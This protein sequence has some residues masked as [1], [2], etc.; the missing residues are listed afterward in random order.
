MQRQTDIA[1]VCEGT[2]ALLLM[3]D[4]LI[5]ADPSRQL[6]VAGTQAYSA[7]AGA[8]VDCGDPSRAA[9]LSLKA[10]E[11][12]TALLFRVQQFREGYAKP[13]PEFT[14]A[15][16]A[17]TVDDVEPLFWGGYSWAQ[18]VWY[19]NG[20]PVAMADL[21]KI[22]R[23]MQ[24]VLELDETVYYGAA[25][26]FLGVYFG[27]RPALYGGNF[28]L[29]R[30]HFER[31]LAIGKREF[32]MAQVL[33]AENYARMVFDRQL[34]ESLLTEVLDFPLDRKPEVALSNQL[35]KNRAKRLLAKID[36]YF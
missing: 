33:Y 34:F 11:Y 5:A 9:Q 19:Q 30:Q 16:A 27:S 28:A 12:G 20:A 31:A 22:E 13:L 7:Y 17:F 2:P 4:G 35:A 29:S 32:L 10:K 1:L 3:I 23:I 26:I 6:L 36:E 8:L 15:L 25:H 24:R 14:R 18:W 21:P